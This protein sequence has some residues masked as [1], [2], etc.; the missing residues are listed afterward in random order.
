MLRRTTDN[1]NDEFATLK[2]W[3]YRTAVTCNALYGKVGAN[4]AIVPP[5]IFI[6]I[7]QPTATMEMMYYC[8]SKLQDSYGEQLEAIPANDDPN[9]SFYAWVPEPQPT[10][11]KIV[12]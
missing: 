5:D 10:K 7:Q 6:I 4:D 9:M 11:P 8:A 2:E 1:F 3:I 12:A